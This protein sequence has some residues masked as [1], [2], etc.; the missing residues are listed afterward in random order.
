MDPRT[1]KKRSTDDG[2]CSPNERTYPDRKKIIIVNQIP[3]YIPV[4]PCQRT[5][6]RFYHLAVSFVVTQG[7]GIFPHFQSDALRKI[8]A[9]KLQSI[10]RQPIESQNEHDVHVPSSSGHGLH[11]VDQRRDEDGGIPVFSADRAPRSIVFIGQGGDDVQDAEGDRSVR[12]SLV[13]ERVAAEGERGG[14]MD[15]RP[16]FSDFETATLGLESEFRDVPFAVFFY[17]RRIV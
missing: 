14:G 2:H 4:L 9:Y 1:S 15:E 16:I 17:G 6:D 10:L 7:T 13:G 8:F 3:D 12:R 11:G 5:G